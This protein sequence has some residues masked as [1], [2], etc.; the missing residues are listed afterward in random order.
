MCLYIVSDVKCY[1]QAQTVPF[2]VFEKNQ[3]LF[4]VSFSGGLF[5]DN[6]HYFEFS[7]WHTGGLFV[8]TVT[9]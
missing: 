4:C 9:L 1:F 8:F 6:F 5:F 3:I 7:K 2:S